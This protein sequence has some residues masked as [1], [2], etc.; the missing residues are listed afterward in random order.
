MLASKFEYHKISTREVLH[1]RL[2]EDHFKARED[3][4]WFPQTFLHNKTVTTKQLLGIGGVKRTK[5]LLNN[6][7]D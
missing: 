1:F 7:I 5:K 2:T 4:P 6:N 3:M